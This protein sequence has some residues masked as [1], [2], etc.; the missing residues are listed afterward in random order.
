MHVGAMCSLYNITT[1]QDAII[2]FVK[3]MRDLSGNIRD[4]YDVYPDYAAPIVRQGS[5]GVRE[6]V[7][8][9]WGM[10]SSKKPHRT[11]RS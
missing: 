7:N 8:A 9:R 2:A 4:S 3:A 5:D 6:L 10:P 11:K 1:N